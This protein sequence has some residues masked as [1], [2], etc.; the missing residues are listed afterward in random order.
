VQQPAGVVQRI[1]ST[2]SCRENEEAIKEAG[3]PAEMVSDGG[4]HIYTIL[5]SAHAVNLDVDQVWVVAGNV[6]AA[7]KRAE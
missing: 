4:K 1:D 5:S 3:K 7:C 2:S 6:K